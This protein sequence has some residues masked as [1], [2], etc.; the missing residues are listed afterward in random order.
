MSPL[1]VLY[2]ASTLG[3]GHLYAM[4]RGGAYRVDR[5]LTEG[6]AASGECDLL[7]CANHSSVAY[8]GCVDYLRGHPALG[9]VPLLGPRHDGLS[10]GLRRGTAGAHRWVR[11]IVRSN[12]FPGLLRDGARRMDRRIHPAIADA[13]PSADVFHSAGTPLPPLPRAAGPRQRFLTV[14]DLA[15]LRFPEMY[16]TAYQLATNASLRS[17]R[18]GDRVMT[19]SQSTRAQLCE[20]GTIAPERISVVAPAADPALFHACAAERTRAVRARY[21][22]PDGPYILSVNSPDPRKNLQHAVRSFARMVSQEAMP[23]LTLVLTGHAGLGPDTLRETVNGLPGARGRVVLTGYVDDGDLAPLYCG[24]TAFVYPSLYEGFGLSA[25]EAMQCGTPVVASNSSSMPE[26][27][28]GAGI[29]VDPH[30]GDALCQAMLDLCRDSALRARMREQ[31]LA[32]AARFTWER[33]TRETLAAYRA[34]LSGDSHA[35]ATSVTSHAVA[36]V[37]G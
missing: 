10:A 4:S 32:R 17:L 27:V 18:D 15:Y 29:L 11:R 35:P 28:G 30:D 8:Q 7:L 34:A 13:S 1:R 33:C 24:A 6:L 26:V 37:T 2:D 9:H 23:G 19:C 21:G 14:Y 31:S 20:L 12:V 25:L 16:A 36:A 5:H 22:I 3:I